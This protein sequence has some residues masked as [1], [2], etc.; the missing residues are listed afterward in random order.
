VNYPFSTQD[1]VSL[2]DTLTYSSRA[3]GVR[4]AV[5]IGDLGADT[6]AGAKAALASISD[7]HNS[8]LI[9]VSPNQKTIE[10]LS[11][12]DLAKRVNDRVAQLGVTAAL[13]SFADGDLIDGLISAVR[14]IT[15]AIVSP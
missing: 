6:H 15:S 5:Y 8:V 13:A 7:A 9:A 10:V 4:F 1:L 14:V 2:D 3:A 11:G 12:S